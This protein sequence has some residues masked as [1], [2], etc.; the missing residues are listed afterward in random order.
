MDYKK[1]NGYSLKTDYIYCLR[2]FDHKLQGEVGGLYYQYSHDLK[3]VKRKLK[4]MLRCKKINVTFI[5]NPDIFNFRSGY[6]IIKDYINSK[7]ILLND[8]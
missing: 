5:E 7:T 8:N 2:V 3:T 4:R 6:D 1:E